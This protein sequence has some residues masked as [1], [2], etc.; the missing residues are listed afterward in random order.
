M[1]T[2]KNLKVT[3]PILNCKFYKK[4]EACYDPAKVLGKTWSGTVLEILENESI[5]ASDR[6]WAA[7]RKGAMPENIMRL[8][9]IASII[10]TK[11]SK[12]SVLD[13]MED[14]RSRKAVEVA[15][16]HAYGDATDEDLAAAAD[17]A[18]GA[19]WDALTD[20]AANAATDAAT[21]AMPLIWA[22]TIR[23]NTK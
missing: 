3:L 14:N 13:L 22:A 11:T 2:T 1:N 12:G 7:T 10:K 9:G 17:A 20:V 19:A 21:D 16:R 5:C 23:D 6:L 15:E 8:C 4:A 18:W